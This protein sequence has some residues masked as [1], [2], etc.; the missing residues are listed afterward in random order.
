MLTSRPRY[1][2]L[3]IVPLQSTTEA[4]L[5]RL[6]PL[7]GRERRQLYISKLLVFA[8]S[9]CAVH[10]PLCGDS[11]RCLTYRWNVQRRRGH[12]MQL[13]RACELYAKQ[14]GGSAG[15]CG[16][17]WLHVIAYNKKAIA[18]YKRAG[19][20]CYRSL[21]NFYTINGASFDAFLM[22]LPLHKPCNIQE[23]FHAQ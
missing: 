14:V 6:E 17:V 21:P 10:G 23:A 12:A 18:L 16:A 13:V 8:Q 9:R 1:C 2:K 15:D 5:Y 20:V 4:N 11:T 7:M 22:L 3:C 19:F